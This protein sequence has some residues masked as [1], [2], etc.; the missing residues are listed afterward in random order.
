VLVCFF[1]S[2]NPEDMRLNTILL[3]LVIAVLYALHQDVWFWR[4]ARPL[5]FGF[6]PAALWYHALYCVAAACLMWMLTEIAWPHHLED[7]E[8]RGNPEAR[9]L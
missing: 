4:A 3:A 5:A 6:L 9:R 7:D 8:E 2:L 1:S